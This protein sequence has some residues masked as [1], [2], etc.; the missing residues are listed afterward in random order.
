MRCKNLRQRGCGDWFHGL[1][2]IDWPALYRRV[3]QKSGG[4]VTLNM[5]TSAPYVQTQALYFEQVD[6][7]DVVNRRRA[8][9][10]L[11][12]IQ[13]RANLDDPLKPLRGE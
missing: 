8:E 1:S 9:Q 5:L 6:V 12:P 3:I 13:P 11:P 2:Q 4:A 10:G 7:L